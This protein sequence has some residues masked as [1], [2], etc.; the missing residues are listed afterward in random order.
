MAGSL[1]MR[2]RSLRQPAGRLR[3]TAREVHGA[4]PRLSCAEQPR[5]LHRPHDV[6]RGLQLLASLSELATFESNTAEHDAMLGLHPRIPRVGRSHKP[7]VKR[8]PGKEQ[9]AAIEVD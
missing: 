5:N 8:L 9:V 3:F 6:H 7:F 1:Q 2:N 4:E